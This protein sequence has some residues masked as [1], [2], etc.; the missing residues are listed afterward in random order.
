MNA[1]LGVRIRLRAVRRGQG[2]CRQLGRLPRKNRADRQEAEGARHAE[3][4]RAMIATSRAGACFVSHACEYNGTATRY[5]CLLYTSD[6][7][8]E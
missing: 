2:I 8:D 7:A 3:V 1:W 5:A 6:A 4:A